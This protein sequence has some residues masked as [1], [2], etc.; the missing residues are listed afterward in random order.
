MEFSQTQSIMVRSDTADMISKFMLQLKLISFADCAMA[1]TFFWEIVGKQEICDF[2]V[3]HFLIL[4][5]ANSIVSHPIFLST[6]SGSTI[7]HLQP[8][9][10]RLHPVKNPDRTHRIED[11]VFLD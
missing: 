4:L 11:L 7:W 10:F 1:N 2:D 9:I 5:I 8:F 6:Q 3:C